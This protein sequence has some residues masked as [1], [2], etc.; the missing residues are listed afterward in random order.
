M[1]TEE[2]TPERSLSELVNDL[3]YPSE[4]DEPVE[5]VEYPIDFEPPLTTEHVRDLLLITPEIYIEELSEADFWYPAITDQD[6]Y[7]EE[8]KERTRRFTELQKRIEQLLNNR[9][10]F[11]VGDVEMDLCLLGRKEDGHWAG[12]KTRVIDTAG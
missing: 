6:W 1:V 3:L 10:V 11:R 12:L 9:Q 2:S 7:V 4:S 5:Y 8:E